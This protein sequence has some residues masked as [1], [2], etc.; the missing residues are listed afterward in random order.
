MPPPNR[1]PFRDVN[2]PP[3][4]DIGQLKRGLKMALLVVGVIALLMSI[5][6]FY[7]TV[8]AD[9]R[10]VLLRLGKVVDNS[11][12]AGLHFKLPLGIDQAIVVPV[13]R[14]LKME[15]GQENAAMDYT[16]QH[17][18]SRDKVEIV[19]N[20]VTG[21]LN[22]AHVEWAV[23]YRIGS[24]ED[25]LFHVENPEETL[26]DAAEAAM[27]EVV[28]DRPLDEVLT[29]GRAEMQSKVLERLQE[30][31]GLYR[32]GFYVDQVQLLGVNPPPQVRTAFEDVNKAQQEKEQL[33]NMAKAAYNA[34]VPKARGA[35]DRMISEAEGDALKRVNEAK[36]DAGKFQAVYEE[37]A[38]APDITRRRMYLETMTNVV[39]RMGRRVILDDSAK[40]V[41]PF[42]P[43][44]DMVA[45]RKQPG[46]N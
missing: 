12:G 11:V 26:R 37:Y 43:L 15:F 20:M 31:V 1:P 21:D 32:L 10:A 41:L 16:N 38:K 18:Y 22:S 36:G 5:G 35:A 40:N 28:G 17:Q 34:S 33:V 25:Y 42:L 39:P 6:S 13:E 4:I 3:Q 27:R 9:S 45:P 19:R 44:N 46:T 8:P 2:I 30:L 29:T 14:Q 23:L 24:L 7:Y